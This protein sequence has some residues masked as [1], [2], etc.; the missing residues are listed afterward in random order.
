MNAL[1]TRVWDHHVQVFLEPCEVIKAKSK[2]LKWWYWNRWRYLH[3]IGIW[4]FAQKAQLACR[5]GK[6]ALHGRR[7]EMKIYSFFQMGRLVVEN[8]CKYLP[9]WEVKFYFSQVKHWLLFW[10]KNERYE[11]NEC[12][13]FTSS[14]ESLQERVKNWVPEEDHQ[15]YASL[16]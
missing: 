15:F 1:K 13:L 9:P 11:L 2:K 5:N 16:N 7:A 10:K 8:I 14:T 3:V 6:S 4:G 12:S